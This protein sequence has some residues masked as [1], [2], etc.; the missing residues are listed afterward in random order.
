M[1]SA[2]RY[3]FNR[4][5]GADDQA[6]TPPVAGPALL[7]EPDPAPHDSAI[8]TQDDLDRVRAEAL[9]FGRKQGAAEAAGTADQRIQRTLDQIAE[10]LA[11]AIEALRNADARQA[12][13]AAALA[14]AVIRKLFPETSRRHGH[15]EIVSVI[16]TVIGRIID[17]PKLTVWVAESLQPAIT[18]QLATLA[19]AHGFAGQISIVGESTMAEGDCRV[20]WAGGG[21]VRDSAAIWREIEDAI[22][23]TLGPI[24]PV[25]QPIADAGKPAAHDT[26]VAAAP[27]VPA[28][29]HAQWDQPHATEERNP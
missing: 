1:A 11:G 29:A 9:S 4:T 20:S 17:K 8:Y 26:P 7:V 14:L 12:R 28:P 19:E 18:E 6:A 24:E 5:F 13:D 22:R 21:A 10:G 23:R 3:L 25:A 15:T 27:S 16:D 2:T